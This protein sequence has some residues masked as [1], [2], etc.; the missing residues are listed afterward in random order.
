MRVATTQVQ[1][2]GEVSKK[3]NSR[4]GLRVK[5]PLL[6]FTVH[7]PPPLLFSDRASSVLPPNLP[8]PFISFQFAAF[9]LFSV[10]FF[11]SL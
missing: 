11:S 10:P 8:Q 9:D 1:G 4:E 7:P 3:K 5:E 6:G 2:E